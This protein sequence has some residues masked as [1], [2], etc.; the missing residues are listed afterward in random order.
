M[1]FDDDRLVIIPSEFSKVEEAII[2]LY[3]DPDSVV[4]HEIQNIPR[5]EMFVSRLVTNKKSS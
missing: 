1:N 5:S 2:R 3:K 4:L